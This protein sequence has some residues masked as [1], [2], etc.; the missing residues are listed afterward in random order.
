[1]IYPVIKTKRKEDVDE[2]S[3]RTEQVRQHGTIWPFV[4][5]YI[6]GRSSPFGERGL[7]QS[8]NAQHMA[9]YE[10][11]GIDR[12][13]AMKKVAADRGVGKREIYQALL[14]DE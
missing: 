12:K 14:K 9:F 7:P 13:S 1:M 5:S 2:P 4:N 10:K 11:Q 6:E 3:T 8:R